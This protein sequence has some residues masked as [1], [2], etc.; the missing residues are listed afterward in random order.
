[1]DKIIKAY[2]QCDIVIDEAGISFVDSRGFIMNTYAFVWRSGSHAL[3]SSR[4]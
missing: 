4:R 3:R 2:S 1:M